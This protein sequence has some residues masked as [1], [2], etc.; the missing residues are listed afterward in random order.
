MI[1]LSALQENENTQDENILTQQQ[2]KNLQSDVENVNLDTAE[3]FAA[4][5]EKIKYQQTL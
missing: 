5:Q 3:S 2:E 4:R 1:L